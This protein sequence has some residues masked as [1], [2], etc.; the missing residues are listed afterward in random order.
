MDR[1]VK[2]LSRLAA[3][4]RHR[5]MDHP[6]DMEDSLLGCVDL[7]SQRDRLKGE[8]ESRR[9]IAK[10]AIELLPDEKMRRDMERLYLFGHAART[11]DEPRKALRMVARFLPGGCD[12]DLIGG[13]T[14]ERCQP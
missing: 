10:A 14:L 2:E 11:L 6:N 4:Y 9:R 1:R 12:H 5:A 7:L 8:L 3:S 13:G